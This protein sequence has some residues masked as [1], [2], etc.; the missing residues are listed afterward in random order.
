[1][2][3]LNRKSFTDKASETITPESQKS[4]LQQGKEAVTDGVDKVQGKLQPE[5]S[6][7]GTQS[8][9]DAVQ[10]GHDDAKANVD[11]NGKTMSET[12]G[13][14]VESAKKTLNDAAEYVSGALT[15][16]KEG[17]AEGTKK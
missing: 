17:A 9:G 11:H 13:E 6:K 12:A 4:Y 7:S 16:A 1:M 5:G 15:G 14:Y 3:D 10:S 2:S 8:L